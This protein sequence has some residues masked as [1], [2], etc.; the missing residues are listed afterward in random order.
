MEKLRAHALRY[1]AWKAQDVLKL[2][3]QRGLGCGHF[4]PDEASAQMRL[5]QEWDATPADAR[6]ML[7]E[8]LGGGYVRLHLA[9]AKAAGI[10]L[11]LVLRLFLASAAA[12]NDQQLEQLHNQLR[13]VDP[14]ALGIGADAWQKVQREWQAAGCPPPSHSTAYR[15]AY[16]PAYRVIRASYAH[17]LPLLVDVSARLTQRAPATLV[18]DGRS[19]SGKSC[20]SACL[21]A[22]FQAAV[23]HMDDF[24]LPPEK[25]T[26]ERL[27]Q[28]G[29]NVDWERFASEVSPRLR[30]G[31]TITYRP[32]SCRTGMLESP[33]TLPQTSLKVV[34]GVYSM[35]PA[36]NFPYDAAFFLTVPPE[37]Q[38]QRI[39]R[40]NGAEMLRRFQQEWIP[41]EEMY[42]SALHVPGRADV[43]YD[44][45]LEARIQPGQE[46]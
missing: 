31:Q 21:H 1:P 18:V 29:A 37:V 17:W 19:G 30:K 26:P 7:C 39:L 20:F 4:A 9:A 2:M 35:H 46:R 3:Y 34:E 5:Q 15:D 38:V 27:M 22:V 12:P 40:R 33:V 41:L 23:I 42:F 45:A 36:L 25:K 13:Q 8:P 6:Q 43:C 44:T 28:P 10:P 11:P 16:H 14:S 32:Y 24:F